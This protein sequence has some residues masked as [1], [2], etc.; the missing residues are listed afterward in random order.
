MKEL[1][2]LIRRYVHKRDEVCVICGY[3]GNLDVAHFIKRRHK[4]TR[5]E[6]LNSHLLCRR[7]HAFEHS[8]KGRHY[9]KDWFL[10]KYGQDEYD[11]LLKLKG[12]DVKFTEEWIS[13]KTEQL[14]A[15]IKN[16]QK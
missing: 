14:Q 16:I 13:Q 12:E 6:V 1:D 11:R 4:G 3:G 8:Y 5:F 2:E 7:C 10:K 9:Y 15:L